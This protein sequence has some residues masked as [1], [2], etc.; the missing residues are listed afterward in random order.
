MFLTLR[1]LKYQRLDLSYYGLKLLSVP[2][3]TPKI[4]P[5]NWK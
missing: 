4:I 2:T 1:H 5:D 3:T